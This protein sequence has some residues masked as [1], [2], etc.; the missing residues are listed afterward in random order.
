MKRFN[1]GE[2]REETKMYNA[3]C[4]ECGHSCKV[5]FRPTGSKPV[6]CSDCFEKKEGGSDYRGRGGSGDFEAVCDDC[7]QDCRVPFEPNP[8]K[9][10]YCSK[11]FEKRGNSHE[12][13]GRS[14]ERSSTGGKDY[15]KKLDYIE[16]KLDRILEMLEK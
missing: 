11:C 16:D 12:G 9:P 4:D 14:R 15:T 10:I 5:P 2:R 8:N 1:T 13:G 7:G 3:M 6:Y